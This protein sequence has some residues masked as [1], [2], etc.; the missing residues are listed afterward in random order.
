MSIS[1]DVF[2]TEEIIDHTAVHLRD[3]DNE[4]ILSFHWEESKV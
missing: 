4:L 1:L 2:T 3:W